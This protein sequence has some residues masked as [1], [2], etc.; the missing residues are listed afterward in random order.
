MFGVFA[1]TGPQIFR[2]LPQKFYSPNY[3]GKPGFDNG[4]TVKKPRLQYRFQ[5]L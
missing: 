5:T 3:S 1:V 2:F 4:Q